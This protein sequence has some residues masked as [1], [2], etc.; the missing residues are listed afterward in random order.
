MPENMLQILAMAGV[1]V[2]GLLAVP[3]V[4]GP[5]L[6]KFSQRMR[7]HPK[8]IP[9]DTKAFPL[10]PKLA[11][12]FTENIESLQD[13]GFTL[14][15]YV[16][17]PDV[18]PGMLTIAALLENRPNQDA[19]M[20]ASMFAGARFSEIGE[21]SK[22]QSRHVE[23]ST[24]FTDDTEICTNNSR[25]LS[26]FAPVAYKRTF[27]FPNVSQ[28]DLLYRLHLNAIREFAQAP[29]KPLP[30][31][32]D[33]F[34]V[35]RRDLANEMAGQIDTGFLYL[36][37]QNG[38]YRPTFKGALLMT[39]KNCWPATTIRRASRRRAANALRARWEMMGNE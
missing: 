32:E 15:S 20:I 11:S 10:P 25:V 6:I 24:E 21:R 30:A 36:D 19:A 22:V 9:L 35:V 29:R 28:P 18:V 23:F 13:A 27:Q 8:V 2:G 34:D 37:E 1:I 38:V 7:A 12:F 14:V 16:T 4:F 5:I 39:W 26:A 31:P 33:L 3:W 17:L